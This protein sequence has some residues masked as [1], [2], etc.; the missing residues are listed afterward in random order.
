MWLHSASLSR[1]ER[2]SRAASTSVNRAN[3]RTGTGVPK[4]RDPQ[5]GITEAGKV[6]LR[7]L[8]VECAFP[9]SS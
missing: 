7:S 5:L 3:K 8:L 1:M 9:T 4:S 2:S 6:Y